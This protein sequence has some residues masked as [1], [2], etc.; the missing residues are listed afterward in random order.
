MITALG[1]GRD[2]M[3]RV[4]NHKEGGIASVYDGTPMR[5][6]TRRSWRR[7]PGGSWR[8]FLG[9]TDATTWWRSARNKI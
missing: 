3:N 5:P 2:A 8:V 9:E 4:Q 1:F 6:R 7:L